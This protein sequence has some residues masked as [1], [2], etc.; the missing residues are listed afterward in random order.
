M[1]SLLY[2][3]SIFF[4]LLPQTKANNS[5]AIPEPVGAIGD[6]AV[7][8]AEVAP[9]LKPAVDAFNIGMGIIGVKNLTKGV[10][11]YA[12]QIPNEVK[13]L[14]Q[15]NESIRAVIT[16]KYLEWRV[17]VANLDNLDD[18][19]KQLIAK[20]EQVWRALGVADDA[21]AGGSYIVRETWN[22]FA[23]IFKANA[24]EIAE[25]AT[26]IKN[27]RIAQNAGTQGN[28]GYLEGT[29]NGKA[30]DSK[31]W[32]SGQVLENEPQIFKAIEIE[33]ASGGTWLRNTDSEYKMLNKLTNDLGGKIGNKYPNISGEMKIISENP[34][35]TSC[36][37]I[38]QQF[39][40]MFPNIKLI[41]IDGVK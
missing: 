40:E 4:L 7:N 24:D 28:Y 13:G 12:K 11:N 34:Y 16:A 17:A 15:K 20:Q 21:I 31:M 39:N 5:I 38:I 9:E 29:V 23:N 22:G 6:I 36:Q 33:G 8:A 27:Y 41:L 1:K 30:V 18:A 25:A 19:K 26:K 2:I 10:A 37:G 14:I 35:C 3:L 32:R